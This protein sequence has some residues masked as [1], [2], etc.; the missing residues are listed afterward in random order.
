MKSDNYNDVAVI[1]LAAG[2]GT[3]LNMPNGKNKTA[4]EIKGKPMIARTVEIIEKFGVGQTIAVVGHGKESVELVLGT[5]VDYAVQTKRLGTGHAALCGLGKIKPGIK[6]IVVVHGDDSHSYSLDIYRDLVRACKI[7]N[8]D[9][10]HMVMY[11]DNPFGLGRIIRDE[12]FNILR[13][14][15]E[16]N[17]TEEEKF[18]KE[19]NAGAY[20]FKLEFAQ[21]YLPKIEFNKVRH[22]KYLTDII[23]IAVKNRKS[24]AS[25]KLNDTKQWLG[26]NTLEDLSRANEV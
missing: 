2:K 23:E 13:V 7:D 5:R 21:K 22:E 10:A 18:I 8:Y 3:R 11:L 15:E 20:C 26:V 25:V 16:K 1:V 14:T 19:V 6:Y 24:V 12:Q 4:L 9:M 17:A